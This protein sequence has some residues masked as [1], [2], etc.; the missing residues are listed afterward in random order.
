MKTKN[1]AVGALVGVLTLALWWNFLMKPG[2]SEASKVKAETEVARTELQPLQAQLAQAQADQAH[3]A[4]FKAQLASLQH[5]VPNSPALAE[6]IRNANGIA[7][8]SHIS[9]QSVTHGPPAADATGVSSIAVGIVVKGTYEQVMD[10]LT[11]LGSLKRLVVVDGVA[12]AASGTTTPGATDSAAASTGPFSG[13]SELVLTI[14]ARMF[15]A[16]PLPTPADAG[17]T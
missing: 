10:Y 13:T 2:R 3:A 5:A 4:T 14:T 1:L 11:R 15:V 7:D 16:S 8:A 6:F 12:F 9:W 17:T